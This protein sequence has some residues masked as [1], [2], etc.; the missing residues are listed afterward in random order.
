MGLYDGTVNRHFG[1]TKYTCN[2]DRERQISPKSTTDFCGPIN[3]FWFFHEHSS[4]F[5]RLNISLKVSARLFCALD[6]L[7]C[8]LGNS[9]CDFLKLETCLHTECR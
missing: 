3:F 7:R 5:P 1:Q 2:C 9:L 4:G 8:N 6:P